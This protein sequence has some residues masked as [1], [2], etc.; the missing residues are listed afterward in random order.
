MTKLDQVMA[1]WQSASLEIEELLRQTKSTVPDQLPSPPPAATPTQP[2]AIPAQEWYAVADRS[3]PE[4]TQAANLFGSLLTDH[5]NRHEYR[6]SPA[7]AAAAGGGLLQA[8]LL[9]AGC[10]PTLLDR[11]ASRLDH[12]QQATHA[13]TQPTT[14]SEPGWEGDRPTP[15]LISRLLRGLD[16]RPPLQRVLLGLIDGTGTKARAGA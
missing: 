5:S 10:S 12:H 6:G 1:E 13:K 4:P 3:Q 2:S 16:V 7:A 15:E 8:H 14:E 11:A 9:R